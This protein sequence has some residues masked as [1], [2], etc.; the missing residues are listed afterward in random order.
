M[1]QGDL[2]SGI[3]SSSAY[4]IIHSLP[5]RIRVR[6]QAIY[7]DAPLANGLRDLLNAQ[8]GVRLART[9]PDCAAIVISFNPEAFDPLDWLDRLRLDDVK[10]PEHQ[11]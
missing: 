4:Q 3:V 6:F 2:R 11:P 9:N 5:G 8:D 10:R 7:R 1:E